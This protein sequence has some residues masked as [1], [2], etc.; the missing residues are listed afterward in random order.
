MPDSFSTAFDPAF[1]VLGDNYY[2][3]YSFVP[4]GTLYV[5]GCTSYT[6]E[7]NLPHVFSVGDIVYTLS[8]ARKGIL[9]KHCIKKLILFDADLK[10]LPRL[11]KTCRNCTWSPLY[12]DTLN[13]YLNEDEL[14]TYEEA[15]AIVQQAIL[16]RNANAEDWAIHHCG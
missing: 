8:K 7:V 9:D 11:Q 12:V 14:L 5:G 16:I 6:E 1:D 13:A 4:V 3:D 15:L 2:M 10:H